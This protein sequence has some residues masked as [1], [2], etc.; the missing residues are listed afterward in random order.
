MQH[1]N[2]TALFL[3]ILLI[4]LCIQGCSTALDNRNKVLRKEENEKDYLMPYKKHHYDRKR[5]NRHVRECQ[6]I[7]HGN[8][9]FEEYQG[10]IKTIERTVEFIKYISHKIGKKTVQGHVA[11][12]NNPLK[13]FSVLYP[14]QLSSCSKWSGTRDTVSNTAILGNCKLAINAGFFNTHTGGCLGNIISNGK[15]LHDSDGIQNANMGIRKNG[16][17]VTGYL[18]KEE[19][20]S[21]TNS[22]VELVSGVGWLIRN[23]KIYINESKKAECADTEETGTIERFFGVVS[24]RSAIG[25]DK[26][27]RIII[28]TIDGKTDKAGVN[29]LEF[30]KLLKSY[31]AVNAINLDGGGSATFVVNGT[32][33][34]YPSDQCGKNTLCE[35]KVSTIIC[36]HEA[37]CKKCSCPSGKP[38]CIDSKCICEHESA[39]VNDTRHSVNSNDGNNE[40]SNVKRQ[41]ET[42]ESNVS[43]K[44]VKSNKKSLPQSFGSIWFVALSAILGG[45]LVL[46]I[47]LFVFLRH[48][49]KKDDKPWRQGDLRGL[50]DEESDGI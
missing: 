4:A 34:N 50:L 21:A 15:L 13:T 37:A 49:V 12:V 29:L 18:P 27:G 7:I 17:I 44:D 24:A 33:V 47:F 20:D 38:Q 8:K 2:G 19:V 6:H 25:H 31:G 1:L 5:S 36:I 23:G 43:A 40:V 30:A 32:V 48:K 9:T 22:F 39:E 46:N 28:A 35:R 42:D 10:Q 16:S 26:E 11:L 14:K 41:K 45:S 3:R